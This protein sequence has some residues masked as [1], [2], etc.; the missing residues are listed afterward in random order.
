MDCKYVRIS[1]SLYMK[2]L[3]LCWRL[4]DMEHTYILALLVRKEDSIYGTAQMQRHDCSQ[5]SSSSGR[6][7][8]STY[9]CTILT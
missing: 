7:L 3:L 9:F 5:E 6:C 2:L 4:E 1:T 8:E